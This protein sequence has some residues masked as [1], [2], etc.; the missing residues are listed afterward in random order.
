MWEAEVRKKMQINTIADFLK[1]IS[2]K[3]ESGDIDTV[4]YVKV[5]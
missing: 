5:K 1:Q 3:T 2:P 4:M